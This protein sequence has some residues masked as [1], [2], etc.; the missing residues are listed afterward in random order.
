MSFSSRSGAL[1]ALP[2]PGEVVAG[3]VLERELA[4]GAAGAVFAAR[5]QDGRRVALKL[6]LATWRSATHQERFKR[7]AELGARLDH[8]GIVKVYAHGEQGGQA[9]LAMELLEGAKPLDEWCEEKKLDARAKVALIEEA[10]AAVQHAH[11][12]GA[13]HRDLKP[14]NILVVPV[15]PGAPGSSSGASTVGG[16]R[17]KVVDLGIAR[18][19]DAARLT[20]SGASIGTLEYMAPEQVR[21]DTAHADARTDVWALATVL[22]QLLAGEPPFR[23]ESSL[24][25]MRAVLEDEPPDLDAKVRGLPRGLADVVRMALSKDPDARHATARAL[26]TDLAAVVA[27]HPGS[28]SACQRAGVKRAEVKRKARRAAAG[29]AVAAVLVGLSVH[30]IGARAARA[31]AAARVTGVEGEVAALLGEVAPDPTA[32]PA[33]VEALRASLDEADAGIGEPAPGSAAARARLARLTALEALARGSAGPARIA[34]AAAAVE[35]GSPDP[36]AELL[37]GGLAALEA[38]DDGDAD[39]RVRDGLEA[40]R[41]AE[42]AGVRRPELRRWR[43]VLRARGGPTRVVART[44]LEE[45]GEAGE[46]AAV[47]SAVLAAARARALVA[48]ED[49][50]DAAQLLAALPPGQPDARWTVALAQA[51][52]QVEAGGFAT[53]LHAVVVLTTS[54]APPARFDAPRARL[55][56]RALELVGP[57]VLALGQRPAEGASEPEGPQEPMWAAPLAAVRLARVLEPARPLPPALVEGLLDRAVGYRGRGDPELA[58]ALADALPDVHQVQR[59]VGVLADRQRGGGA[60]RPFV[61]ALRR[62]FLGATAADEVM[63]LGVRLCVVLAYTEAWEECVTRCGQLLERPL[64]DPQRAFVHAA[65][66]EARRALGDRRGSLADLEE[67]VRLAPQQAEHHYQRALTLEA[68]GDIARAC[69]DA[70]YTI[71]NIVDEASFELDR[72]ARLLWEASRVADPRVRKGLERLLVG[73]P[74]Y[75]GWHLRLALVCAETGDVAAAARACREAGS[76]LGEGFEGPDFE[77]L[78]R[79]LPVLADDLERG[80]EDAQARLRAVVQRLDKARREGMRP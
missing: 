43:A 15:T 41:R 61:A 37:R 78:G 65:R 29:L 76:R 34:L 4:R 72:M 74:Q 42:T 27:G 38:E 50:D 79:A 59:S 69:D 51:G 32:L 63:E 36:E 35:E 66:G 44:I 45:L 52:R 68:L 26:G 7:E 48:L 55:A 54:V 19:L 9:W 18:H 20:A 16:G 77:D 40:L 46:V 1:P 75:A 47:P 21:G 73:R 11:D 67:A 14:S 56:A 8:P 3:L 58:V 30:E 49:A 39:A 5:A 53:A 13:I 33:K 62:A 28:A 6:L 2:K 57:L 17:V 31:R 70:D 60:K 64:V 25:I 80:A 23:A 24:A 71:H 12:H 22:H 10:C